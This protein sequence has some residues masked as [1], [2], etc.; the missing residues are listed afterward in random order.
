MCC[1]KISKKVPTKVPFVQKLPHACA[2]TGASMSE[3]T[4]M[5]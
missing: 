4:S 1:S 3:H 5:N 2:N